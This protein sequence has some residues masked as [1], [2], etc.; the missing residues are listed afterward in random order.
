[1][2][3]TSEFRTAVNRWLVTTDPEL[4]K[5][6]KTKLMALAVKHN[7]EVTLA[8]SSVKQLTLKKGG[9]TVT[10]KEPIKPVLFLRG[11]I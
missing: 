8:D 1:M 11:D 10:V 9:E 2:R 5:A 3:I 6:A 7:I 4:K